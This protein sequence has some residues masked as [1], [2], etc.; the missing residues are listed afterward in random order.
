LTEKFAEDLDG[1]IDTGVKLL[2][3]I[4]DESGAKRFLYNA[5]N[6]EWRCARAISNSSGNE[7][8]VLELRVVREAYSSPTLFRFD[9]LGIP[10]K[11]AGE[12]PRGQWLHPDLPNH[13]NVFVEHG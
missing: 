10:V 11:F 8:K 1:E 7:K 3:H 13:E 4:I 12:Y 9:D 5:G 2:R 6:H